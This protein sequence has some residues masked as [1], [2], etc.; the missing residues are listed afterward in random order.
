MMVCERPVIQGNYACWRGLVTLA[1][2]SC[3]YLSLVYGCQQ[4]LVLTRWGGA[5]MW[6]YSIGH[7]GLKWERGCEVTISRWI[8]DFDFPNLIGGC[9]LVWEFEGWDI[10]I[11]DYFTRRLF[12]ICF[13]M[14]DGVAS[15]WSD[16][17]CIRE[18]VGQFLRWINSVF[19]DKNLCYIFLPMWPVYLWR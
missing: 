19:A 18:G 10:L 13:A 3:W 7:T 11:I 4:V 2:R 9:N 5:S 17:L 15:G 12:R 1:N 6:P 8:T 16:A 14:K